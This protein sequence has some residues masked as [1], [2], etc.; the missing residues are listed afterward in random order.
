MA[1]LLS[2]PAFSY[3]STGHSPLSHM[4]RKTIG[5]TVGKHVPKY[6]SFCFGRICH[7]AGNCLLWTLYL[8]KI[9]CYFFSDIQILFGLLQ[10][11]MKYKTN[12]KNDVSVDR[13]TYKKFT[14][15]DTLTDF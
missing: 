7:V 5:K 6:L 15:E 11:E 4:L 12:K 1:H 8:K 10:S 14:P 2:N 13:N 9:F 3:V